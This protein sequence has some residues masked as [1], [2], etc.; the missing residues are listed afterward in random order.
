MEQPCITN[1]ESN[2][3]WITILAQ[4]LAFAAAVLVIFIERQIARLSEKKQKLREKYRLNFETLDRDNNLAARNFVKFAT[5]KQNIEM[6]KAHDMFDKTGFN[7]TINL[8]EPLLELPSNEYDFI[9]EYYEF[10]WVDLAINTKQLNEDI[11]HFRDYYNSLMIAHFSSSEVTRMTGFKSSTNKTI[12]KLV[13]ELLGKCEK[14]EQKSV[15]FVAL[16]ELMHRD[17]PEED[18]PRRDT[19]EKMEKYVP[20]EEEIENIIAKANAVK[21]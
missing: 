12:K 6:I 2:Q 13:G 8:P 18:M 3:I 16:T 11:A 21:A 20:S 5:I 9:A 1:Q 10:S 17:F 7:F 14:V 4:L 19:L 15:R